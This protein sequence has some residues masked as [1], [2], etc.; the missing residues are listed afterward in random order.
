MSGD[1]GIV[2]A[3][4]A[5]ARLAE[6]AAQAGM[7]V[8]LF[9]PRAPWE[10]PCGG[11]VTVR[12]G[13]H[14]PELFETGPGHTE[15]RSVRV[16]TPDCD[17]PIELPQ[18]LRLFDRRTLGEWQLRRAVASGAQ[19]L[20][21][22]VVR[23]EERGR[24]FLLVDE[25]GDL[26]TVERLA[27]ADGATSLVRR[28]VAPGLEIELHP[29]RGRFVRE[30]GAGSALEV[31]FFAGVEGY[32]W[33][34][35]RPHRDS[36]GICD[37]AS[38]LK[39]SG[40]EARLAQ[41]WPALSREA[42]D[43]GHPLPLATAAALRRAELFGRP[44]V[45]LL[46]DAAGLCDAITGEGIHY[47]L[48]SAWLAWTSLLRHGDFRGYAPTLARRVL[49]DLRTAMRYRLVFYRGIV[50][51]L[52]R[53]AARSPALRALLGE[54]LSGARAY[55]GLRRRV[56]RLVVAEAIAGRP[57][58]TVRWLRMRRSRFRSGFTTQGATG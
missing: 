10:K 20:G 4:P 3:G 6:L 46:G 28:T 16:V 21:V 18:P 35:P 11:G 29:T 51:D 23:L 45:V 15:V 17:V 22:R 1:L 54:L 26:H 13:H 25:H 49:P 12:V 37:L 56:L 9:D 7:S 5:G 34:F 31:M 57:W 55:G 36:V 39:R 30:G 19:F 42:E 50:F 38:R 44:N 53:A 8:L 14:F 48:E 40:L 47:A 2:G 33:W 24:G 32:A 58:L 43:Y 52:V 27:G 41:A